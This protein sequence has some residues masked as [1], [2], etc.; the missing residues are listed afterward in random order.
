MRYVLN[1]PTTKN[2]RRNKN[3]TPHNSR[4]QN[5]SRPT[6]K[7]RHQTI[8]CRRTDKGAGINMK[9]E[10]IKTMH[11]IHHEWTTLSTEF[12]EPKE[13]YTLTDFFSYLPLNIANYMI[14]SLNYIADHWPRIVVAKKFV[15]AKAPSV[16]N[17]KTETKQ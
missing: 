9:Y 12:F 17:E 2:H 1:A 8:V 6:K 3:E 16:T 14:N 7:T 13:E 10:T 15:V 5:S 11:Q 4:N